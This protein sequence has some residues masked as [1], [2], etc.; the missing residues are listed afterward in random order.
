MHAARHG[1]WGITDAPGLDARGL[2]VE[3]GSL[4]EVT[5]SGFTGTFNSAVWCH[6]ERSRCSLSRVSVKQCGGYGALYCSHGAL[7]E[8]ALVE[9]EGDFFC[10]LNFF[11]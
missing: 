8:A 6:G 11:L 2:V 9:E 3:G 10:Y 5:D 1:G 7:L 4:V